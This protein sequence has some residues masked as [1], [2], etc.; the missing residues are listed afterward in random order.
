[1]AKKTAIPAGEANFTD[2]WPSGRTLRCPTPRR[3]LTAQNP[4]TLTGAE[5]IVYGR[6]RCPR[7]ILPA[8]FDI[9]ILMIELDFDSP[10]E[11]EMLRYLQMMRNPWQNW[12]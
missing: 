2:C 11:A 8:D 4:D 1:M 12:R 5:K 7:G 10:E 6:N 9:P 3:H